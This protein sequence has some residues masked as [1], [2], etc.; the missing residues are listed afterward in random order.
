MRDVLC[1]GNQEKF[2]GLL[3]PHLSVET[4]ALLDCADAAVFLANVISGILFSKPIKIDCY[5]D[6]SPES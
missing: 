4:L 1:I 2:D 3:N 6:N 5:V